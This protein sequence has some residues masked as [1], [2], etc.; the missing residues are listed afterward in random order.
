MGSNVFNILVAGPGTIGASLAL[1]CAIRGHSTTLLGRSPE[2]LVRA[3]RLISNC[4]SELENAKLMPSTG[5]GWETRIRPTTSIKDVPTDCDLVIEAINE[6][7]PAKQELLAE[8]ENHLSKAVLASSTSGLPADQ[9]AAKCK[10][11]EKFVVT[12][13]A[14]P[15]HLMPVVEIVPG[16][17]TNPETMTFAGNFVETLGKTPVILNRDIPGHL[18]NR[19]QFA[20]LREAMALVEDGV[21][22][23][24]QIDLVVKRGLALR[25]AEEGPMEKIDLAT[26]QLVHDVASYLY[27][28]LS[29]AQSPELLA[30]MLS[31]GLEGAK[32]GQGFHSWDDETEKRVLT[33]RN[34]EVIRHLQR[35]KNEE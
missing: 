12:H 23:A 17:L 4:A 11:P 5:A 34:E 13:F 25:L 9:I 2:S 21:A 33:K 7:L 14:N 19:I 27:P 31:R 30:N 26:I 20:M 22:S 6:H 29:T 1:T 28:T 24:D 8:L 3:Q 18:F 15:P 10:Q 16:K 35:F 32:S